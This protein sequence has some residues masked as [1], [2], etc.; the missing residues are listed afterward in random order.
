MTASPFAKVFGLLILMTFSIQGPWA[1]ES[2]F[3]VQGE[4]SADGA[5]R[6]T[7]EAAVEE[8]LANNT[9]ILEAVERQR[10]AI[11]GERSAAADFF[12]KFSASYSYFR[13]GDAPYG[14]FGPLRVTVG[15]R[16]R[17][18]WDV[19]VVQPLFTGFALTTRRKIAE[20]GVAISEI[21]REQARLDVARDAK[22]AYYRVLLALKTVE[23][24]REEVRVLASHLED[25]RHYYDQG[26]IALNDVLKS[27][28]ALA[29]AEQ[30]EVAAGRDLEVAVAALNTVLRRPVTAETEVE[31][32]LRFQPEPYRLETLLDRAVA[33]RPELKIL[34]AA[35]KQAEEGVRL[36][37]SSFYPEVY[38]VGSYEQFGKDPLAETNDFQNHD[39]AAVGVEARWTFF[40]FGKTRADVAQ[41]AHE[42]A[43]LEERVK[44]IEDSIRLEV[45]AAHADLSVAETNIRTAEKA[46]EQARENLR[47]TKLQYRQQIVT[48]TEVLDAAAF[49]TGARN[50]YH[51]ALYGYYTALAELQRAVGGR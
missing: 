22:V 10:A 17:F 51:G 48:S 33:E 37:A 13:L 45:K 41:R 27:E 8:A 6:L 31:D 49:L 30:N 2:C 23:V 11:Q 40:E 36:A 5:R 1:A 7:L 25:A 3:G 29:Q 12:P 42:K 47:I 38:L 18:R 9:R 21:E 16:D 26:I 46:L 15:H 19:T 35:V 50:N 14:Q 20:L 39:T 44:R 4:A 43:A 24:A 32:V 28:V 34:E